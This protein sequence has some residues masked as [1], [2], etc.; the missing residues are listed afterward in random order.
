MAGKLDPKDAIEP[1]SADT[2]MPDYHATSS[3]RLSSRRSPT[4]RGTQENRRELPAMESDTLEQMETTPSDELVAALMSGK[5]IG[6]SAELARTIIWRRE[7]EAMARNQESSTKPTAKLDLG[8]WTTLTLII[9][10]GL[11][12]GLILATTAIDYFLN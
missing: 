7:A 1:L 8:D 10:I 6:E 11:L 5:L 4:R 12:L 9:A 3:R 2:S